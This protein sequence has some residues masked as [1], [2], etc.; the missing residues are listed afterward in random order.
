MTSIRAVLVLLLVAIAA[1]GCGHLPDLGVPAES[2]A[3][4]HHLQQQLAEIDGVADAE[5]KVWHE[6]DGV[7]PSTAV[8]TVSSGASRATFAAVIEAVP[9]L[10]ADSGVTEFYGASIFLEE[11]ARVELG[12]T[13]K[14]GT[15][16]P[17]RPIAPAAMSRVLFRLV[18]VVD[19]RASISLEPPLESSVTFEGGA[20]DELSPFLHEVLDDPVLSDTDLTWHVSVLARDEADGLAHATREVGAEPGRLAAALRGYD[21]IV[22]SYQAAPPE[23]ASFIVQA[24]AVGRR[25]VSLR[26]QMVFEPDVSDEN[27]TPA[28]WGERLEPVLTAQSATADALGHGSSLE[29]IR[30]EDTH[31]MRPFF[32]HPR[33]YGSP[34]VFTATMDD[35]VRFMARR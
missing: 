4:A 17:T 35:W 20:E 3:A 29:V 10:V 15:M 21:G 26:T 23:V 8:L 2:E 7:D 19:D 9:G 6:Q 16:V 24:S 1:G 27:L 33:R 30:Q 12:F 14:D 18:G 5:V 34:G 31:S 28:A 32:T 22:A 11:G 13:E 25:G